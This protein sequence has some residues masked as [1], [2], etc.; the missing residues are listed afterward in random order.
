MK[1]ILVVDDEL[2]IVEIISDVLEYEGYQVLTASNGKEA[3]ACLETTQVDLVLSDIMMPVMDGSE[4]CKRI[5]ASAAFS[6]IPVVL[7][8]AVHSLTL[9]EGCKYDGFVKK[10][11]QV[12]DLINAVTSVLRA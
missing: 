3:F 12:S 5:L 8:S 1:T 10:P 9:L 6:S 4:L 2:P 7:M 11:F